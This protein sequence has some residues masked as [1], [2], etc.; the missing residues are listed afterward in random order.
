MEEVEVVGSAP[1]ETPTEIEPEVEKLLK[2]P[3]ASSDPLASLQALPGVT[4]GSD[5]ETAPAV[6]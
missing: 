4:F 1:R 3:G 5:D 6:P 2:V